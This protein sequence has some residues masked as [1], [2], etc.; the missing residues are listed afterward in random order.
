MLTF[1]GVRS[2]ATNWKIRIV[3]AVWCLACFILAQAYNVELISYTMSPNR[4][5]IINSAKDILKVPGLK[6]TV[7]RGYPIDVALMV[8][9]RWKTFE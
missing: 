1:E 3:T 9:E 5:P 6:L 8:L 4:Q 2:F 7:D